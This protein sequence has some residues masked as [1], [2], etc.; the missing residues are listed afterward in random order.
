MSSSDTV[1]MG[2]DLSKTEKL[3]FLIDTGAEISIV[4]SAS[5]RQ[6]FDYEPTM[7]INVREISNALLKTDGTITFKLLTPTH[8]NTHT[9]HVMGDSFDC[10][11]NEILDR[12]IWENKRATI[13]YCDR[14]IVMCEVMINFDDETKRVISE[15]Y[16]LT[17]KTR[18]ESIVNCPSN[19]RDR[20]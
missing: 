18:T 1:K 5:R 13:N 6:V 20:E 3:K 7:E 10:Q 15:T 4:K 17:L 9:F 16:K 12:D 19:P 8:E 14:T 2:V 11:Y